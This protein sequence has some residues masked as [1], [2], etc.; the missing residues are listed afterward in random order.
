MNASPPAYN[1]R[2]YHYNMYKRKV[3]RISLGCVFSHYLLSLECKKGAE[4][5]IAATQHPISASQQLLSTNCRQ[6]LLTEPRL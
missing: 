3:L 1:Q 4:E 2:R 6:P 5:G